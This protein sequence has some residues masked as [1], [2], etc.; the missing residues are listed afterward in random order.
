[1]I[2]IVLLPW[3]EVNLIFTSNLMVVCVM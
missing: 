3:D 1:V 2:Q